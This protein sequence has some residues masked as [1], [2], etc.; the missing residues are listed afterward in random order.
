MFGYLKQIVEKMKMNSEGISFGEIESDLKYLQLQKGGLSN[1]T[2]HTEGIPRIAIIV[3]YRDRQRNLELFLRNMHPFLSKQPIYYGIF[4]VEPEANLTFNKGI[5]M[6]AGFLESLK[7]DQ[8]DCFI[9]HDVDLLPESELNIYGCDKIQPR[10]L[11]VAISAY[12]Y[13]LVLSHSLFADIITGTNLNLFLEL[14][15][16]S[17][18]TLAA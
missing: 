5:S 4:I 2:R 3:P 16:I 1:E 9:F 13:S 7:V 8:W 18:N 12:G 6:N 14:M 11:A 15:D 17:I 10:L